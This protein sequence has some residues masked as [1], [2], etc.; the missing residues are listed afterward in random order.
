MKDF[1]TA[2]K[3]V[4]RNGLEIFI[5]RGGGRWRNYLNNLKFCDLKKV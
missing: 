1:D 5:D 4:A 2:G 3:K